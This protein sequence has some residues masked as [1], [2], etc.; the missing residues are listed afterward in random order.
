MSPDDPRHGEERGYFAHHRDG[1][2]ACDPCITGHRIAEKRRL[3]RRMNGV[4][5]WVPALGSQRRIQALAA[6]GWRFADISEQV[7][8][9]R[10]HEPVKSVMTQAMISRH[11]AKRITAAYMEL[12]GK[13]GPSTRVIV[14][15][16]KR[17]WPEPSAWFG[18]D[19]DDP[20]ATPDPGWSEPTRPS[21]RAL[22]EDFDWL[23]SQGETEHAAAARIGV[24]L[25]NFRDSR[26]R[27]ERAS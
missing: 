2:Q 18:V 15:A 1:E 5:S 11:N 22:I 10:A 23:V 21:L 7:G 12:S 25:D 9:K 16:K 19:I 27:A 13:P 17:G 4:P 3:L 20:D 14:A 26:R 8:W 6:I 24:R